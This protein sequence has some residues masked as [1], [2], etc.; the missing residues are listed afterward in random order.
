MEAVA[1]RLQEGQLQMQ[2]GEIGALS[3]VKSG[4]YNFQDAIKEGVEGWEGYSKAA[5]WQGPEAKQ[6]GTLASNFEVGT[7]RIE[8]TCA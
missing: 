3:K 1:C 2:G 6:G 7:T 8:D 5:L 4:L